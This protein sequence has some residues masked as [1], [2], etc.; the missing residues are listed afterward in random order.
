MSL[1]DSYTMEEVCEKFNCQETT[2]WHMYTQHMLPSWR[3]YGEIRFEKEQVDRIAPYINTR[4][5]PSRE[6]MIERIEKIIQN[7]GAKRVE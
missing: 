3:T 4:T 5:T 7:W 6:E 2:V 1:R